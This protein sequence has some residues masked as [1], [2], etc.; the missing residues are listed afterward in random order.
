MEKESDDLDNPFMRIFALGL[1]L[2]FLG[3]QS[4]A[5]PSMEVCKLIPNEKTAAFCELVVET[6]AYAGSGNV[7]KV[8]KMLHLCA[9]H[10]EDEKESIHQVAAV[11]GV[12]LI[13]FGEDI[14]Q[15]MCLRTMN[16]LLQYGEPIIKRTVPL[17]MGLLRISNP[18]VATLDLLN[19]LA[20][21]SDAETSMTAIFALG[22]IGAGTNNSKLAGN[23]RYL[24]SYYAMD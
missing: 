11:I 6:C 24:A 3:Q 23:L 13:A 8:Q 4:A 9:E 21:D 1:G 10:K 5:E 14:G 16:H 12:A 15:Q 2:L 22:L 18:D 19:K 20:Y 17:A 7:L